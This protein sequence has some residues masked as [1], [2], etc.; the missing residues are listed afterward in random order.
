MN[1]R[2]GTAASPFRRFVTL[3]TMHLPPSVCVVP[4]PRVSIMLF[5]AGFQAIATSSSKEAVR[6]KRQNHEELFGRMECVVT[7]DDPEVFFFLAALEVLS[8]RSPYIYM[9]FFA[10]SN[11]CRARIVRGS[12]PLVW[13]GTGSFLL[14]S[15]VVHL[16][17]TDSL[18][19]YRSW[20]LAF[21]LFSQK[22]VSF[23]PLTLKLSLFVY[24][25]YLLNPVSHCCF[26]IGGSQVFGRMNESTHRVRI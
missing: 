3:P 18:L 26:G 21:F 22:R 16:A 7:G 2:A 15:S 12:S 13:G 11:P 24:I 20:L 25:Q 14:H 23:R 5:F 4:S 8:P 1:E 19:F 10:N 6:I 9:Y 17:A